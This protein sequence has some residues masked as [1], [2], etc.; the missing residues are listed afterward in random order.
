MGRDGQLIPGKNRGDAV[1]RGFLDHLHEM[2]RGKDIGALVA[3]LFGGHPLFD[4]RLA[5]V[6]APDVEFRGH[7]PG[8]YNARQLAPLIATHFARLLGAALGFQHDAL[9]TGSAPPPK[10]SRAG[11]QNTIFML[12]LSKICQ[13]T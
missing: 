11:P 1:H 4:P 5:A 2:R 8:E 3:R 12:I 9:K 6:S 7:A 10:L 13:A